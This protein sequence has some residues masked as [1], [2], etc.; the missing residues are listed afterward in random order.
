MDRGR[1][2]K[3]RTL[4]IPQP[5]HRAGGSASTEEGSS[6]HI[7]SA[8]NG[9][10]A[11]EAFE[12]LVRDRD[13]RPV[14]PQ[15]YPIPLSAALDRFLEAE[16]RKHGDGRAESDVAPIINFMI[17]LIGD[18]TLNAVTRGDIRRV[19]EALP[20]IP[21]RKKPAPRA[22]RQPLCEVQFREVSGLGQARTPD[23]DDH[24]ESLSFR[25]SAVLFVSEKNDY[26]DGEIPLFDAVTAQNMMPLP[27]DKFEDSELKELV[28][29]PLFT[30]CRNDHQIWTPGEIFSQN[31]FYWGFLVSVLTGMRTGEIGQLDINQI[32][33]DEE[34]VYFNLRPFDASKGRVAVGDAKRMKTSNAARMVPVHPL[35]INL[36]LLDRA[37]ELA[38]A[39]C[40][41]LFPDCEPYIRKDGVISWSRSLTR[42]FQY[43]KRRLGWE[44]AD[45]QLY[46]TRHLMSHWIDAAGVAGRTKRRILGHASIG[47]GDSYGS[48]GFLDPVEAKVISEI[49]PPVVQEMRYI[50]IGARERA[51]AGKLKIEK[52]WLKLDFKKDAES[53][54]K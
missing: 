54:A 22:C 48:K 49:E 39:G 28:S 1:Y 19:N 24:Q 45:L 29:Q 37:A 15:S 53:R 42:S 40:T 50:L 47:I 11:D 3:F 4:P 41:R 36:G 44:R 25:L 17:D 30:G 18:K 26:W 23:D 5:A 7:A 20:E 34:F 32:E 51:L 27:R 8:A 10:A 14:A 31:F 35:L 16:K 38:Q 21:T 52:P 9:I 46:S 6:S 43:V 2:T 12:Q 33:T 13:S